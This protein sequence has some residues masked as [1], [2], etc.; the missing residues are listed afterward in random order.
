MK[1]YSTEFDTQITD[2]ELLKISSANPNFLFELVKGELITMTPVGGF[3]GNL[4]HKY[5]TIIGQW[6]IQ[7]N[8]NGYS[9]STGFKLPNGDIRLPDAAVLLSEHPILDPKYDRFIPCSPDF[10][11]EVR[12]KSN[13]LSELKLKMKDWVEN[14]CK[15]AFMIDP[16]ERKAYVYRKDGSV[17][18]YPYDATLSGEDVL[19]GFSVCPEKLDPKRQ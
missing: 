7:N 10:L 3:S 11:I 8:A 2:E 17:T 5:N 18:E 19:P 6:C 12:S 15:L 9:S 4:E 1:T 16:L 13:S 14:G